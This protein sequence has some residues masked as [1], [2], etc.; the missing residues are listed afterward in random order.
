MDQ[1]LK[2][3]ECCPPTASWL[4]LKWIQYADFGTSILAARER[5]YPDLYVSNTRRRS[6]ARSKAAS[7]ALNIPE[8]QTKPQRRIDMV[9]ETAKKLAEVGASG[10]NKESHD[11]LRIE[12]AHH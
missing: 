9:T 7:S 2:V 6:T 10:L 12:H 5:I 8:L 4:P 3:K 11:L 1:E